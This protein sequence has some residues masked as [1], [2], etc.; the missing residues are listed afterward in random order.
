VKGFVGHYDGLEIEMLSVGK[1]DSLLVTKW[2]RSSLKPTRVLIDGGK[3][4]SVGRV[5]SF[6]V[7]RG[8]TYI[9]HVICSHPHGDHAGGLVEL[10]ADERLQFGKA[11][12]HVPALHVDLDDVDRAL[13]KLSYLKRARIVKKAL[14]T[15]SDLLT[16]LRAKGITVEEP[17][18]NKTIAFLEV[19]GPSEEYYEE[20]LDQFTDPGGVLLDSVLHRGVGM[21]E[22]ASQVFGA[23]STPALEEYPVTTPEN[24]SS[25][26]LRA[27]HNGD[28]YLFSADAGVPALERAKSGH[29]LENC[30]WM[31][32]PHHGSRR[33]ITAKLVER[34]RPASA[35]VSADGSEKHPSRAVVNA[36]KA[37]GAKVYSTHHPYPGD[38]R[39]ATGH[40][41]NRPEYA[42]ISPL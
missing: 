28:T 33:N 6:L 16:A 19:C 32:I 7:R 37:A 22:R 25:V 42:S 20:L 30:R 39:E 12:M 29:P 11:W 27:V 41:P 3:R 8:A 38:L 31:Q 2:D 10:V 9:D 23:S 34:F 21:L 26:I 4:G 35:F 40:V 24:N 14:R 18:D 17:F 15:A 13:S 1:A 36:F 5:R